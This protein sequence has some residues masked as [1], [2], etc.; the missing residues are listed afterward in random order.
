MPPNLD[1][2]QIM[3]PCNG[4]LQVKVYFTNIVA[5]F[6]S[7]LDGDCIAF[8]QSLLRIVYCILNYK[9]TNKKCKHLTTIPANDNDCSK[10]QF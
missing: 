4:Y 6:V 3:Q 2:V 1:T 5:S 8:F 7:A 9:Q 10:H